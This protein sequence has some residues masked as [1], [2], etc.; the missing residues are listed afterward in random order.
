MIQPE[1]ILK[2]AEH[3]FDAYLRAWVEQR[4][5]FPYLIS[6]NQK[7][8]ERFDIFQT[9]LQKLL[10]ASKKHKT[11]GYTVELVRRRTQRLGTQDVPTQIRFD[12][13]ADFLYFLKK[14]KEAIQFKQD[15]MQLLKQFPNLKDWILKKPSKLLDYAGQWDQIMDVLLYYQHHLRPQIYLRELPLA[16]STKFVESNKG[17]FDSLFKQLFP[18]A[19]DQQS[20]D[21]IGRWGFREKP[22]PF[23]RLRIL[24]PELQK[25]WGGF[26]ELALSLQQLQAVRGPIQNLFIIENEMT[27]LSFPALVGGLAIWGQGNQ[28][29][30]LGQ[31]RTLQDAQLYY[32]GDLDVQGLRILDGLRRYHPH[33]RSLLMGYETLL[34]YEHWVQ[35]GKKDIYNSSPDFLTPSEQQAFN[36][37]HT[38]TQR[39]EQ[40]HIPYPEVLQVLQDEGFKIYIQSG[41]IEAR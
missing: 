8:P 25:F 41:E 10:Q 13:E 19:L 18:N 33:V 16:I 32:W 21:F 11:Q 6:V 17:L 36:Y 5:F 30:S 23:F 14:E 15:A 2:K 9:L 3:K 28:A 26:E 37:L 4:E 38:H 12:T 1:D 7:L 35:G 39:L 34:K 20:S 31:W 40:E 29:Q 24:D 22:G 27:Y